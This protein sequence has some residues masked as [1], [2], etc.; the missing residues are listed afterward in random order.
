MIKRRKMLKKYGKENDCI[1]NFNLNWNQFGIC[2]I[3]VYGRFAIDLGSVWDPFEIGLGLVWHR[4]G[5]R[6]GS[7][8]YPGSN[9]DRVG[10]C[11][12]TLGNRSGIR[13]HL[14][15]RTAD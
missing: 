14:K 10:N 13:N 2:Q 8:V 9:R 12:G 6:L 15:A 5:I 7:V 11:L 1:I 4:S 3:S